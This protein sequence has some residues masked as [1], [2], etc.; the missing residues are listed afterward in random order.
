VESVFRIV[1]FFV[2]M[3]LVIVGGSAL[4]GYSCSSCKSVDDISNTPCVPVLSNGD[5]NPHYKNSWYSCKK[6]CLGKKNVKLD[7]KTCDCSCE[8]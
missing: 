4:F 8:E 7:T 2:F 3:F 1:V 6:G 5:I